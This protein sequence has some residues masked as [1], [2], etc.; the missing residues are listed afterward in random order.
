MLFSE[1]IYNIKNLIAGGIQS[2]DQDL[3]DM[4]LAFIVNYYRA[5]LFKQDQEKSRLNKDSYVQNLGKVT[6]IQAD[7]NE[8]YLTSS[9]IL[10]TEKQIPMPIE[11]VFGINLTFVGLMNG[12]P[13]NY[14]AHNAMPWKH[15]A[16]YV[17][18]EPTYYYQ[19]GYLYI[20]DPPTIDIDYIN[21]QGV[22][23]KPEVAMRFR[24]CECEL[25]N[26]DCFD[27]YD[28]EYKIPLHYVDTLVKM[29]ADTE[30]K[31]LRAIPADTSNNSVS[32]TGAIS[33]NTIQ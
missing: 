33:Q 10:R 23:E 15:A 8:C 1:I 2:D 26:L 17:G 12:R 25:N 28:F 9:C 22:F 21:I 18:K 31:L 4:Q 27:T 7:K 16:K 29:C 14:K 30:L 24:S 6:L 11:S 19:N 5:R 13:F 20:V 32:Q 3:S